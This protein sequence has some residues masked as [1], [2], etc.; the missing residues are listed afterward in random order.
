MTQTVGTGGVPIFSP[1][2][3]L[4]QSPYATLYNRPILANEYTSVLGTV[5]DIVLWDP[6]EYM[7]V[8]KGGVQ[9]ASSIHVGF[10]TDEMTYRFTFRVNGHPQWSAALTPYSGGPTVSPMVALATRA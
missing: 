10:L 5:G 1:P 2:G 3:G 8:D 7:L 4:S 9:S 6:S